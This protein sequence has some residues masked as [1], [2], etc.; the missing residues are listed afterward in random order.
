MTTTV[1]NDYY[2]NSVVQATY[3]IPIKDITNV[4]HA[5]LINRGEVQVEGFNK[6]PAIKHIRTVYDHLGLRQ[7]KDAVEYIQEQEGEEWAEAR[8]RRDAL[9]E[10]V[11]DAYQF[12]CK[13]KAELAVAEE[14]V[15][16]NAAR[17][18]S[19][20]RIAHEVRSHR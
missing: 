15:W 7:A 19:Q 1:Q 5:W 9:Q 13:L 10:Q 3:T 17:Y 18:T 14:K 6:I 16:P 8:R 11:N 20:E 12:F 2:G 4:L